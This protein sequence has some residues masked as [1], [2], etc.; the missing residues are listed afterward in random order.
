MKKQDD[1]R[2]DPDVG[3]SEDESPLDVYAI[4]QAIWPVF[5]SQMRYGSCTLS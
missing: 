1:K 3:L 5:L 4:E 2:N